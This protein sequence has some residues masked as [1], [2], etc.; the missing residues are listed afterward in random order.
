MRGTSTGRRYVV[1]RAGVGV[2]GLVASHG[3][4]NAPRMLAS[5]ALLLLAAREHRAVKLSEVR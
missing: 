1:A 5:V 4:M 2:A 3:W